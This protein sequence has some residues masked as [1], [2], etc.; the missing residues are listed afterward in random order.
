MELNKAQWDNAESK[1]LEAFKNKPEPNDEFA[2]VIKN[3]FAFSR[4]KLKH[5]IK[6]MSEKA[7]QKLAEFEFGIVRESE[8]LFPTHH[9]IEFCIDEDTRSFEIIETERKKENRKKNKAI[10]EGIFS[11]N[12]NIYF[13]IYENELPKII[14]M[15][16]RNTGTSEQAK[17]IFQDGLL[18]VVENILQKKLVLTES[19]GTYLIS[20]CRNLWLQQ[21]AQQKKKQKF[22]DEYSYES[23]DY[24][25]YDEIVDSN[26]KYLEIIESLGESC[27]KLLELYYYRKMS[28]Q[29]ITDELGYASTGS[30]RNQKYKCLERIRRHSVVQN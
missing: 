3:A 17:D 30:A 15:V 25:N 12:P 23:F 21:I 20:V 14:G 27:K 7:E 6:L 10:I 19:F 5:A 29:E 4:N 1:F 11:V 18:I 22:I 28:W 24:Y 13:E 26:D 16:V 9:H 2:D 8:Y